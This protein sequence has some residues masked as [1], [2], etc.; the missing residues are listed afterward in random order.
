MA[1]TNKPRIIRDYYKMTEE[2]Q[3]QIK[4]LYPDGFSDHLIYFTYK[5]GALVSALPYETEDKMYLLRMTEREAK[6]IVELDDDYDD[7]GILKSDVKDDLEVKYGDA[8]IDIA[9]LAEE[10]EEEEYDQPD[11][12]NSIDGDD[13]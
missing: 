13:L 9:E 8:D 5:D 2:Q 10:E 7:D 1:Q 6:Q 12:E 11:P 4:L 3:E